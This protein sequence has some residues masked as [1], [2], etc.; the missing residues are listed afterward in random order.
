M[1]LYNPRGQENRALI[2]GVSE[3]D[4]RPS[5]GVP[6]N[7]P[8]IQGNRTGLKNAL[9]RSLM[10]DEEQ[11]TVRSSPTHDDF[12]EDLRQATQEATGLLLFYFAGHGILPVEGK[13]LFLQMRN[14][15]VVPGGNNAFPGAAAITHVLHQ[16]ANSEAER[17]VV[18][19]DCCYAGN[20]ARA[21]QEM[22]GP[23]NK[24]KI[25]LLMSVQSN[26][27]ITAEENVEGTP[28]TRELVRLLER[29]KRLTLRTL[30]G[31][32]RECLQIL[33]VAGDWQEPQGAWEPDEDVLLRPGL[34]PQTTDGD[35]GGNHGGRDGDER[36]DQPPPP[37]S[38]RGIVFMS[39]AFMSIACF[40][41]LAAT[42]GIPPIWNG[43]HKDVPPSPRPTASSSPTP[44]PAPNDDDDRKSFA[45]LKA[46]Q[47]GTE[48]W[49]VGVKVGQPG[50]S[51][52]EGGKW[53]GKEIDYAKVILHALGIKKFYFKGVDT[54]MRAMALNS[55]GVDMFVGTYG[56]SPDRKLG[57]PGNP[58]VIFAGPYFKTEQKI[59]LEHY[60]GSKNSNEAR[61]RGKRELVRGIYDIPNNARLCVVK[62]SSAEEY[63]QHDKARL[64]YIEHRTDYD[65][66]I[67]GLDST[68]D[69]VLTDEVI[70]Q[71]FK[72]G[73]KYFIADYPFTD[74]EEYGIG[75]NVSDT[76]VKSEICKAI[77][78][79]E[80]ERD[81]IYKPLGGKGYSPPDMDE[82]D[83]PDSLK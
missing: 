56:I 71:N 24:R 40:T 15:R 6:G 29:P 4:H 72:K 45:R 76:K 27:L 1:P 33:T 58:A 77:K 8:N 22:E 57:T 65:L 34:P 48:V 21:W 50:L 83:N 59:M 3:Y 16:L 37:P 39:I 79:T 31:E 52:R 60:P 25:L 82:C 14:A 63:L 69:A 46:A 53:S 35:A 41:L 54:S 66:C 38:H 78:A 80:A 7:L 30:Y 20:A 67:N 32:L 42:G 5:D 2:V 70:L 51:Q 61:I 68:F 12:W 49:R 64:P 43:T 11:I 44:S 73:G 9:R 75:L 18:I 36:K 62:G 47:A 55:G 23:H 19:L 17:I 74:P 81:A 13:E 26:R 28:F 10:F